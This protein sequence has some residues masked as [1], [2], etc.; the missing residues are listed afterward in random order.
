MGRS[1]TKR[2]GTYPWNGVKSRKQEAFRLDTTSGFRVV[3]P[4]ARSSSGGVGPPPP[5]AWLDVKKRAA[6]TLLFLT[7]LTAGC[8]EDPFVIQW[9]ERPEESFL[10]SLDREEMFRPTAFNIVQRQQVILEAGDADGAWDFAVDREGGALVL[11]PPRM[12][13]LFGGAGIAP[14]RNAR[15]QDVTE[16]PD[17]PTAYVEEEPVPVE[18]GTVYVIR[19][20][21]Q[22]GIYGESC[23]YFG[24]IQ[25]LNIDLAAGILYFVHDVS[26]V[27]NDPSL[28]PR[29]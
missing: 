18:L 26:P 9:E 10:Y 20:R 3:F 29:R 19:S 27:C 4:S 28:I 15:F 8:G 24:K 6:P 7:L 17:S 11:L 12:L 21:E 22:R 13:G 16:A 14:I 2:G 5:T 25:A 23:N 1:R